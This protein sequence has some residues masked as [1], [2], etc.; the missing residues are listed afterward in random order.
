MY[1]DPN[2]KGQSR[3][4][5][6]NTA[7]LRQA[8]LNDRIS[9]FRIES[10]YGGNWG[11]SHGGGGGYNNSRWTYPQAEAMVRR[12]YLSVLEREPDAASRSYIDAV[13]KNHWS[14]QQLE[15]ELRKSPEYREKHRR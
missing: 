13:M 15:N 12:A 2:F 9:S 1:R 7:D 11:G 10:G 8:G 5:E 14:Q 3:R 6:A 4:F